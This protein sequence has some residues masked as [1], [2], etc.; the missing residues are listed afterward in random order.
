MVGSF[1]QI[2]LP[3]W[4]PLLL[5]D[6]YI[7]I[8]CNIISPETHRIWRDSHIL[9][10]IDW[11][12][13][14]FWVIYHVAP[15]HSKEC[16]TYQLRSIW[17]WKQTTNLKWCSGDLNRCQALNMPTGFFCLTSKKTSSRRPCWLSSRIH[18]QVWKPSTS[19]ALFTWILFCEWAGHGSIR[20]CWCFFSLARN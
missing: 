4:D 9:M 2:H 16:Q 11:Y 1:C 3:K 17:V 8:I 6:I 12:F 13:Y 7:Y 10:M 5:I 15:Y 14:I 19:K 18:W 20:S